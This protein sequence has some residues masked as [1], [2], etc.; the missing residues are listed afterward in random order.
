[1]NKELRKQILQS[2]FDAGAC[3][4]GSALSCVEIL[5]AIDGIKKQEDIFLFSKASGVAAYY[6]LLAKKGHF[7]KEK[8]A[9]YLKNFPLASKEI[10]GIIHSVGSLGH[11]LSVSCGLALG[12]RT[13]NVYC[14]V[15]DGELNEGSTWEATLFAAHHKLNNLIVVVDYNKI[16]ACGRTEDILGLE[17]LSDKFSSFGWWALNVDGHDENTL[18]YALGLD[19]I[20]PKA[21]IAHT[22]KGKG[23]DFIEDKVE[24]HYLNLSEELLN[25]ALS[26]L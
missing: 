8:I 15:S 20:K 10:S 2:S 4:I 13:R 18:K 1:M 3:H 5:L 26:Q 11:G 14:L 7:P 23:V 25:K 24:W 17:K 19:T 12:D 6:A 22:I 9:H 21:I 16:Q